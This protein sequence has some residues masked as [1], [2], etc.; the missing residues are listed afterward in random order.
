MKRSLR[1]AALAAALAL[2]SCDS[3]FQYNPNEETLLDREKNLTAKNI[4]RIS[5]LPVSDTTRFILMGDSQRWYDECEDF[6]KSANR[7]KDI[8]FVLHAGD[9]SDF[10]LTQEFKWVNE[11]MTRLKYPYLTVIG[12]HDIIANGSSTYRRMF[13]PLNYTF[14]FGRDKFIFIDSNSREYA[15][16]GSVPDVPWLKAQLADNPEKKNTI[17]V[18]HVPPFDADF[19]KNLEKPFTQALADD[20]HVKFSLY[21]HQH[22]FYEGEFYDDGVRYHLTTSMGA[23]GYMVVSTWKDGYKVEKVEF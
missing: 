9:I 16:D 22:R 18:A 13:G 2:T 20:P 14:T 5:Q 8:S 15:F 17:V 23:R 7:Q 3:L 19:D 21:G 10:G 6:V 1:L 11:I 4:A 12:N